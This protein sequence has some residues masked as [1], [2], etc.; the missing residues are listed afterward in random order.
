MVQNL[1]ALCAKLLERNTH[2]TNQ[3][4]VVHLKFVL[5][6]ELEKGRLLDNSRTGLRN[7]NL[8]Y[9]QNINILYYIINLRH[10]TITH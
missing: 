7:Q 5:V 8:T 9:F 2:N 10:A 6:G 4:V 1:G 3:R